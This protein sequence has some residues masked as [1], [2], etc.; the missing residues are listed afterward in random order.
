MST[1]AIIGTIAELPDAEVSSVIDQRVALDRPAEKRTVKLA[2]DSPFA[3][4]L[5]GMTI[6][7]LQ[8]DA[9]TKITALI[10]SADGTAQAIPGEYIAIVSRKVAITAIS[11]VR[12]AGQ[13]ATVELILGQQI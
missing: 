10:T 12:V 1:L 5:D 11:L 9:D 7:A 3:V 2:S 8:I 4:N 13:D 6:N